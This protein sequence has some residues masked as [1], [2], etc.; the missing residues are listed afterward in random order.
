MDALA[1]DVEEGA[2]DVDA[3]HA[4]HALKHGLFDGV[5]GAVDHRQVVADQS[6]QEAGGAE[7]PMRGADAGD[8]L[9]RGR[10]VEQDA[11][12]A[13]DLGVDIAGDQEVAVQIAALS[14]GKGDAQNRGRG[15]GDDAAVVH[16]HGEIVMK[17]V[18]DQNTPVVQQG[19]H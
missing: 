11:A 9:D 4:G 3:Q 8:G 5:D 6:R 15:H 2:F 16:D 13:V 19:G 10:I 1:R 17:G 14:L 7:A 18:T 12:A